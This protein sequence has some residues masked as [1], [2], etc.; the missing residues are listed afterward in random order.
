MPAAFLAPNCQFRSWDNTGAPLVGGKVFTYSAGTTTPVATFTDSTGGT[1]NANPVILNA[2]GEAQIY[3]TP[4]VGYKFVL[5]DSAGNPIWTVDQIFNSQLLTLFGGIDTG[6]PNNY[7]LNFPSSFGAYTNGEVI[8]WIPSNNNVNPPPQPTLNVNGLGPIQI[9]NI[10]GS[11]LGANQIVANRTAQVM[12]YNG[13]FQLISVG[14]FTGVTVGTFGTEVAL[15]SA[16]TTDVGSVP[17]HTGLITGNATITSFG[18]SANLSAPFYMIR[19]SGTPILTFNAISLQLPTN[20]S[21]QA[22]PGD[23][24]IAQFLGNGNWKITNYQTSTGSSIGNTKIKPAD[25]VLT[26]NATLTPDPDLQSNPLSIGRYT[27][28]LYLTFDSVSGAAGFKFTND[29]SAVDS[30]GAVPGVAAGFINGAGFG[31]TN[32]TFYSTLVQFATISTGVNSNVAVYKGSLLVGTPGTF[33]I[34]WAQNTSTAS[35]TTLRAGSYLIL[36]LLTTG[37]TVQTVTHTYITPGSFTE[38][39]PLGYS[40]VTVEVFGAGGFGGTG[41]I[42]SGTNVGGGGGGSGGY[43]LTNKS[44]LGLGGQTMNFVVG[45]GGNLSSVSAGTYAIATMTGNPGQNGG[46][47][48][49]SPGI[50]GNGGTATG[51]L[52]GNTTGNSGQSGQGG[53]IGAGGAGGPGRA[54]INGGGNPGAF[55]ATALGSPG[56][57]GLGVV[58]FRYAP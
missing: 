50:G 14:N 2:R 48:S 24:A 38:T 20:A 25:T 8:Y 5:Q 44:V 3:L 12:Y 43:A 19:F 57:P 10:D 42:F 27:Y 33:G 4:N 13:V 7:I 58:I 39:I 55:G 15:P 11:A 34:S 26:S 52:N 28:E 1:P 54:G 41:T 18:N 51:G 47:A 22:Q 17:A 29:G 46:S 23:A 31:P 56:G 6:F 9:V 49:P 35:A 40:T 32:G 37:S 45:A 16:A 53:G 30:R 21:I 36:N